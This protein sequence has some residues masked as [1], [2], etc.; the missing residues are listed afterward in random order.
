MK[1]TIDRGYHDWYQLER[2]R[3]KAKRQLLHKPL[4]EACLRTGKLR[5]AELA[6]HIVPHRG[7]ANLFWLGELQSLCHNCHNTSKRSEERRG[8]SLDIG[9]DG[10][11]LDKRHPFYSIARK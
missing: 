6:D 1:K 7:D 5:V 8:Y 9:T 2:W 10:Y 3:R 4:C 11:P